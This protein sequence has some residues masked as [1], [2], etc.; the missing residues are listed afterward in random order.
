MRE[1]LQRDWSTRQIIGASI[2]LLV[3]VITLS[4][5]RSLA[6]IS[7]NFDYNYTY[8]IACSHTRFNAATNTTYYFC[9]NPG[10]SPP[11]SQDFQQ[12]LVYTTGTI[13]KIAWNLS[14]FTGSNDNINAFVLINSSGTISTS[15]IGNVIYCNGCNNYYNFT[16]NIAVKNNDRISLG[17]TTTSSQILLDITS[18]IVYITTT[19]TIPITFTSSSTDTFMSTSTDAIVGNVFNTLYLLLWFFFFF[20]VFWI[21][22]KITKR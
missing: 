7:D 10:I 9:N 4:P 5:L 13:T 18:A 19:G 15:S 20:I 22:F 11:T 12:Q 6:L 2:I 3:I 17:Y 21:T 1:L 14:D 16:T 8:S